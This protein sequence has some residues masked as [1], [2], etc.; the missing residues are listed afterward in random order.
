M[1]YF[2]VARNERKLITCRK[3]V[4]LFKTELSN[5]GIIDVLITLKRYYLDIQKIDNIIDL[6]NILTQ[7]KNEPL[8]INLFGINSLVLEFTNENVVDEATL[9]YTSENGETGISEED[10]AEEETRLQFRNLKNTY[11]L[12]CTR[13]PPLNLKIKYNTIFDAKSSVIFKLTDK[14]KQNL[15][16][17]DFKPKKGD[18]S[19]FNFIDLMEEQI[20]F[21]I[22]IN[23]YSGNHIIKLHKY[24]EEKFIKYNLFNIQN[25]FTV[26]SP[27][28]IINVITIDE[29]NNINWLNELSDINQESKN[30]L[31]SF[32]YLSNNLSSSI[33]L[34]KETD[35][36]IFRLP[37]LA[38]H[39]F[40]NSINIKEYFTNFSGFNIESLVNLDDEINFTNILD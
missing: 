12:L 3:D 21:L 13:A 18:F 22:N 5:S 32:I 26:I 31:F 38:I 35:R 14:I 34:I 23:D 36:T 37:F 16:C 33:E 28:I 11:K 17:V 39:N 1:E 40:G 4:K 19:I 20:G 30:T 25:N 7:I 24:I 27:K 8:L 10:F 2:Y 15:Y 9:R 6:E 29:R